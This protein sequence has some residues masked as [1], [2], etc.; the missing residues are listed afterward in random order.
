MA[1]LS[2]QDRRVRHFLILDLIVSSHLAAVDSRLSFG[3][4]RWTRWEG[5]EFPVTFGGESEGRLFITL[6][7][8]TEERDAQWVADVLC[9]L[10]D[11]THGPLGMTLSVSEVEEAVAD[12]RVV[13]QEDFTERLEL[14][15]P[16]WTAAHGGWTPTDGPVTE[17]L[18][19]L[20]AVLASVERGDRDSALPATLLLSTSEYAFLGDSVAWALGEE[21]EQIAE[22]ALDRARIEQAF[23]NAF[24]AIE[25]LVGGEPP[26]K[27]T[28]FR[29]RLEA[30][31][32]DADEPVGFRGRPTERLVDALRRV[33][34]TR[35]ARAAHAGRTSAAR[36]GITFYELMEA[37]Y[38]VS[39]AL[40]LA[41]L[42]AAPRET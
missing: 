30:A 17:A 11:L 22:S 40:Q 20:P 31:G 38:A 12:A 28:R 39:A 18:R 29:A 14:F 25:A 35:D 1:G 3:R 10:I 13:R 2:G 24:K 33:G 5:R 7:D 15:D 4:V 23:H 42:A 16:A 21:G 26:S 27:E 8:A 41:V 37:Q 36:R 19:V 32:V 9:A 34:E 6:E